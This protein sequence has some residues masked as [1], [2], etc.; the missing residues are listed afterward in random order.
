MY[1]KV[2]IKGT[3]QFVEGFTI[4]CSTPPPEIAIVKDWEIQ[5]FG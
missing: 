1:V 2:H 5:A 3:Q 4:K